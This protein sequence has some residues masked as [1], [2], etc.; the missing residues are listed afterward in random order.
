MWPAE[1]DEPLAAHTGEKRKKPKKPTGSFPIHS[2]P[3]SHRPIFHAFVFVFCFFRRPPVS[4]I[5]GS[6]TSRG[7]TTQNTKIHHFPFHIL[8]FS[9][10]KK[11]NQ[12]N[13]S[14]LCV[15][16]YSR[17]K[18]VVIHTNSLTDSF[19]FLPPCRG[20]S[21]SSTHR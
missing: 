5:V 3:S 18:S 2:W 19:L 17:R 1:D 16:I 21:R 8:R 10:I 4:R 7:E 6:I 15:A 20:S 9:S 12:S 13:L 14:A 11:K